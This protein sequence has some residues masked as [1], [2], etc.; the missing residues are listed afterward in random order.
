MDILQQVVT[1]RAQSNSAFTV[2]DDCMRQ[3]DTCPKASLSSSSSMSQT[4][5]VWGKGVRGNQTLNPINPFCAS[6]LCVP[7]NSS[8]GSGLL[9]S[10]ECLIFMACVW[11]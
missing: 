8:V 9:L 1:A 6:G 2:D 5:R 3:A 10:S 11:V 7:W 4:G